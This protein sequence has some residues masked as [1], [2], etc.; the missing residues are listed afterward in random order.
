MSLRELYNEF[1]QNHVLTL[2]ERGK[3]LQEKYFISY[4]RNKQGKVSGS[5]SC[6]NRGYQQT[7]AGKVKMKFG[8]L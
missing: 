7:I 6:S 4:V 5:I 3:E 2:Q 8:I 1:K